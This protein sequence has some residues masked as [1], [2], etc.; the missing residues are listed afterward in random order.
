MKTDSDGVWE[1]VWEDS[2]DPPPPITLTLLTDKGD[3]K[4]DW[5]GEQPDVGPNTGNPDV[6]S[7]ANPQGRRVYKWLFKWKP[8]SILYDIEVALLNGKLGQLSS[9]KEKD[10][11]ASWEDQDTKKGKTD[12]LLKKQHSHP[13]IT[14]NAMREL[15]QNNW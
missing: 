3:A 14:R 1:E 6:L 15:F 10:K 12:M 7:T 9:E 13:A 8:K 2:I 5:K 4:G 11:L